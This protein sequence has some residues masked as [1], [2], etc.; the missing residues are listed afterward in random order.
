MGRRDGEPRKGQEKA[1]LEARGQEMGSASAWCGGRLGAAAE[2]ARPDGRRREGG[3]RRCGGRH[4]SK[5][6]ISDSEDSSDSASVS[7]SPSIS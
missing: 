7:P 1:L 3:D 2:G 6:G 5:F 4:T